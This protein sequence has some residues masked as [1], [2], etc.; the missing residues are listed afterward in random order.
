MFCI[1]IKTALYELPTL[2]QFKQ[3]TSIGLYKMT[4]TIQDLIMI[5]PIWS[6]RLIVAIAIIIRLGCAVYGVLS[7]HKWKTKEFKILWIK[8]NKK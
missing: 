3:F 4:F 5:F 6:I 8:F 7:Y 2:E 1:K